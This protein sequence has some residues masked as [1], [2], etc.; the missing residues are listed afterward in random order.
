MSNKRKVYLKVRWQTCPS[1]KEVREV[2]V[3]GISNNRGKEQF[4]TEIIVGSRCDNCKISQ[5][6][7]L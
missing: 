7:V 3:K 5:P 4:D 2:V 1:C 6:L